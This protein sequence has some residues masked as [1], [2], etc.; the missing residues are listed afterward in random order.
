MEKF[1]EEKHED[2]EKYPAQ[3]T[4]ENFDIYTLGSEE[5]LEYVDLYYLRNYVA[6]LQP[7]KV[8]IN[9]L[10]SQLREQQ[11]DEDTP[12]SLYPIEIMDEYNRLHNDISRVL[13]EHPKWAD[14][15]NRIQKADYT[16][17][18]LMYKNDVVD[19]L[20]RVLHALTDGKESIQVYTFE[21]LPPEAF[22]SKELKEF[23]QNP[24]SKS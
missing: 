14:R 11:W 23:L 19:G 21:S 1:T 3:S 20:H 7:S 16:K 10:E 8:E 17:P 24:S 2:S 5:N 13:K 6:D 15:I 22:A 4:I 12:N 9:S 18:I